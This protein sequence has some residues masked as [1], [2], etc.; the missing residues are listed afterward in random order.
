MET[1]SPKEQEKIGGAIAKSIIAPTYL[2]MLLTPFTF[3]PG[4]AL[5]AGLEGIN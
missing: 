2:A 5:L 1:I 3:L 4:L